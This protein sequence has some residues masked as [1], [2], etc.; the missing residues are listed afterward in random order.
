[1]KGTKPVL[2]MHNLYPDVLVMAGH[3]KPQSMLAKAMRALNA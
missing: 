2:I 1:L 3:L